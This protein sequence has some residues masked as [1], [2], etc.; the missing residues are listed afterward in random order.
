MRLWH[1]DLI[2]V[3]PRQQ[4]ISQWRECVAI[5][6][7]WAKNGEK[8]NMLL[9]DPIA[10]YPPEMLEAYAL[11]V[12][13]EIKAR[14]YKVSEGAYERLINNLKTV[15]RGSLFSYDHTALAPSYTVDEIYVNWMNYRYLLQCYYNLQEKYDRGGILFGDWNKVEQLVIDKGREREERLN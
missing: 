10:K 12:K 3:L 6:G 11:L 14:G 2:P 1:K 7:M 5:S 13:R 9:V 4:L 8:P 15:A